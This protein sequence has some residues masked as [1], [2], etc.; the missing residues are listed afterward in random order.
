[1]KN[2]RN[3][4]KISLKFTK[5]WEIKNRRQNLTVVFWKILENFDEI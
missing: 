3:F 1:M 5:I 4:L 2:L